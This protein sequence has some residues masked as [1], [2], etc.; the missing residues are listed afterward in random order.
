MT[1]RSSVLG[2]GS[3]VNNNNGGIIRKSLKSLSKIGKGAL[4]KKGIKKKVR[5]TDEI[6]GNNLTTVYEVESFK[7][8][9]SKSDPRENDAENENCA[10][11]CF[12]F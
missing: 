1:S 8:A 6:K 10:C 11:K 7:T 4:V 12:I 3:A 5:F 9:N 2:I